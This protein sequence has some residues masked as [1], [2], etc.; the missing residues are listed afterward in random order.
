MCLNPGCLNILPVK[1]GRVWILLFSRYFTSSRRE[2]GVSFL[3]VNAKASHWLLTL[4]SC[5]GRIKRS[6]YLEK[7]LK[8]DWKFFSLIFL[9]LET[10]LSWALPNAAPISEG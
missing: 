7:N 3:I 9:N 1:M 5:F 6:S 4:L 2:N 8:S 10:F